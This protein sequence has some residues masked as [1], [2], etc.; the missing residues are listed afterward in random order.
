MLDSSSCTLQGYVVP[1]RGVMGPFVDANGSM[2][3]RLLGERLYPGS[4]NLILK[5]PIRLTNNGATRT[6]DG[7]RL[8]WRAT[9]ND[10]PVWIYRWPGAPLHVIEVVSATHLR[11]AFTLTNGSPV[12]IQIQKRDVDR[13]PRFDHLTWKALWSGRQSL[14]HRNRPYTVLASYGD[15]LLGSDQRGSGMRGAIKRRLRRNPGTSRALDRAIAMVRPKPPRYIFARRDGDS[16]IA[17]VQNLL[18]YGKTSE[19]QYAAQK[20]PA[21]YH[22]LAIDGVE[23]VGQRSPSARLDKVPYNFAGKT[24]LDIG[25]NQGGMLHHI[26]DIVLAGIGI[27]YDYRVINAAN[28]IRSIQGA[29]NLDF[30]TFNLET[31]PLD[32]IRDFLPEQR[33]DIVFLLSVCMWITNW[34]EVIRFASTLAD[35]MLFESNGTA[36]QQDDQV[37]E[38]EKHYTTVDQLASRSEDDP[39]QKNRMLFLCRR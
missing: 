24:V 26:G 36:E 10:L 25:C 11:T 34:R 23:I 3:E 28:R 14:Y 15:A 33:A 39:G 20:F 9:L 17:Q 22:T 32:L 1:G 37:Q 5:N 38:L 29:N 6:V 18:N 8:F 35:T 30:Y 2:L 21:G 19:S 4:L 13:L 16:P 27:D 31:E 7:K 12:T